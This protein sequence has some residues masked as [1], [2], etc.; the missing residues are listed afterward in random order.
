MLVFGCEH[1]AYF[2]AGYT[3][4]SLALSPAVWQVSWMIASTIKLRGGEERVREVPE[5]L[6]R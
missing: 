4:C 1:G 6:D 2:T 3:L 5:G